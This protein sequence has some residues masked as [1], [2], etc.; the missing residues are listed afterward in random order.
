MYSPQYREPTQEIVL[1]SDWKWFTRG[2]KSIPKLYAI[3]S[4]IK[5]HMNEATQTTQPQPPSGGGGIS[6]NG[7][8]LAGDLTFF[9]LVAL[10]DMKNLQDDGEFFLQIKKNC[11]VF[12]KRLRRLLENFD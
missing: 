7:I 1:L 2:S 11:R 8:V 3:P 6:S 4:R 10:S 12:F 9:G 5:L